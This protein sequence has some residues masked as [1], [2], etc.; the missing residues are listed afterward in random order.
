MTID[1][2]ID[3]IENLRRAMLEQLNSSAGERAA[4]EAEHGQVWDTAELQRDFSVESFLAPFVLA[5]RKSDGKLGT[6]MFQHMPRY[7]FDFMGEDE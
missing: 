6:L 5:R 7:Y 2:D 4:L 3:E 1:V